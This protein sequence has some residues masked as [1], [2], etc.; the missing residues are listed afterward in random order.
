MLKKFLALESAGGFVLFGAALLAVALSNSPWATGFAH[1]L[2]DPVGVT[3]GGIGFHSSAEHAV[4]DGLMVIFFLLVGLEIKR[5]LLEGELSERSKIMLPA[6]AAMGGMFAP[7]AIYAACN[8]G[9]AVALRGWAIPSATDIAFSLGVL[10]LLGSRVPA[11]LKIF[12]TALAIIDDLG[13]IVII[14]VFYTDN[15]APLMLGGAAAMI[16][17]LCVLNRSGVMALAPYLLVGAVLWF[18]VLK[19]GVHATLAGVVL[20]LAI[21]LRATGKMAHDDG[22]PLLRL[23][24]ALHPWVAF[25]VL[26]IFAFANAGV[27][28]AGMSP[29]DLLAPIPLGIAAGLLFGKAIGIFGCCWL[30]VKLTGGTLPVG[31]SWTTLLGIALLA[32]IGFT[33]SLF[34]GTLAFAQTGAQAAAQYATQLRL[35]VIAGSLVAAVAGYLILRYSSPPKEG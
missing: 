34:I 1:L 23:E 17:V 11:S 33:M 19:S 7:S 6:V 29:A 12:L 32:G 20:A 8:W 15:L 5:E 18:F 3:V 35:G 10:T 30:L 14:A 25:G 9:D 22:A 24:H 16:A 26:P 2:H 4:N 27:S 31:A 28:F 21:P 13:A